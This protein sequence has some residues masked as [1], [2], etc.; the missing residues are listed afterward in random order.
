MVSKTPEVHLIG[1]LTPTIKEISPEDFAAYAAASCFEKKSSYE[2][3]KDPLRWVAE[4]VNSRNN[5][6]SKDCLH[7][8]AGAR[9]ELRKRLNE[10]PKQSVGRGHTAVLDQSLFSYSISDAPR[11]TTMQLCLPEYLMH[12]QQSMRRVTGERGFYLS[13]SIKDSQFLDETSQLLNDSFNLYSE[14]QENKVAV[15]DS[16]YVLPIAARTSIT[17]S[18]NARELINL[19]LISQGEGVPEVTKEVVNKMIYKGAHIAPNLFKKYTFKREGKEFSGFNEEIRGFFPSQQLFASENKT[20]ERIITESNSPKSPIYFESEVTEDLLS[21]ALKEKEGASLSVLKHIHNGNDTIDGILIPISLAGNHQ[22]IRERTL[23]EASES[24][25]YAVKR[26]NIIVPPSVEKSELKE[27]F[28]NQNK[29]MFNLYDKLIKN[30][31][32]KSEAIGVIPHSLQIYNI[33][34]INGWNATAGFIPKRFCMQ[35]QWEI[36]NIASSIK[37]IISERS[38]IISE[39]LLPRGDTWGACPEARP[40]A[41]REKT[42]KCPQSPGVNEELIYDLK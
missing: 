3:M 38:P 1:Y 40:C 30:K 29:K 25:Y 36:R 13:N 21:K 4:K 8:L 31:I 26:K 39:Y 7:I 15:E 11:E 12:D 34:H 18:G 17:T 20:L 19:K 10:I 2:I 42:S 6:H 37:N 32:P 14:L 33:A 9:T 23:N 5:N 28:L 16:R 24:I 22:L 41:S 35:A 27:D